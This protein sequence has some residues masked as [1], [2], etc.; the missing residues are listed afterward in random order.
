MGRKS[1]YSIDFKLCVVDRYLN[2]GEGC[3]AIGKDLNIP[4]RTVMKWVNQYQKFGAE[5]FQ[6][7]PRN[8]SYA[9]EFKIQVIEEYLSGGCSYE[10]LALKY[11]IPSDSIIRQWVKKYSNLEAVK[12]YSPAPEV[13]MAK[14][15]QTTLE[16]RM[17]AVKWY[18]ENGR[19]YKDTA[20]HFGYNYAQVRDWVKKYETRGADGLLDRRGKRKEES[21][22]TETERLKRE[23]ILERNKRK[24]LEMENELLKKLNELERW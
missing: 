14:R 9:K 21:E 7:K 4:H 2:R 18:E 20:A 10:E 3:A 17:E 19:S 23:L 6:E 12:D 15:I 16:Q 11:N 24:Q 22:L 1:K 8:Q 13:Y 5:A